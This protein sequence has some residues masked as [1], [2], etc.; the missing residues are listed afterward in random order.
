LG[1]LLHG[2]GHSTGS[3]VAQVVF[4]LIVAFNLLQTS[5]SEQRLLEPFLAK[6]NFL[7][8]LGVFSSRLSS[9]SSAMRQ[10]SSFHRLSIVVFGENL[11]LL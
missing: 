5:C 7:A 8:G 9:L 11:W 4:A 6:K 10:K 3:E 1:A 2:P